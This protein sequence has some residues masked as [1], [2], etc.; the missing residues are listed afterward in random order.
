MLFTPALVPTV[1]VRFLPG[2][3]NKPTPVAMS[4]DASCLALELASGWAQ[5]LDQLQTTHPRTYA[6]ARDRLDKLSKRLWLLKPC[7]TCGSSA[8]QECSSFHRSDPRI[9]TPLTTGDYGPEWHE[10]RRP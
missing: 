4:V 1:G 8:G 2:C 5:T 9:S 3:R 6:A 10:A 7:E